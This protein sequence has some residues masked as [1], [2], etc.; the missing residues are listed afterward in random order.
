MSCESM[1]VNIQAYLGVL[2]K[3]RAHLDLTRVDKHEYL[4]RQ[5]FEIYISS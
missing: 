3:R 5:A 1:R 4:L 2:R